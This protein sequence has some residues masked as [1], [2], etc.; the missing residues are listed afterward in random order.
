M[1]IAALV[2]LFAFSVTATSLEKRCYGEGEVSYWQQWNTAY[3]SIDSIATDSELAVVDSNALAQ[4]SS[5]P[6]NKQE[7]PARNKAV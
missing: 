6:A 1:K 5:A 7:L 4:R 2:A 3:Q